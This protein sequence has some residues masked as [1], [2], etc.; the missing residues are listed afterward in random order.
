[1]IEIP[2]SINRSIVLFQDL[3]A[4]SLLTLIYLHLYTCNIW[5]K[6]DQRRS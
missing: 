2:S 6:Q 3:L 5:Q 4:I 1:M